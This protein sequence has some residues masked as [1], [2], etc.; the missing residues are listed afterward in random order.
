MDRALSFVQ[1]KSERNF[2]DN[3]ENSDS[4]VKTGT[5]TDTTGD[6]TT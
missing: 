5:D 2:G 1:Y 6:L 3:I 4:E